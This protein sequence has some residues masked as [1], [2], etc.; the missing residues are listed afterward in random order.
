M[1]D[2]DALKEIKREEGFRLK[3]YQD[4]EGI[5]TI[6]YG[7][8]LQTLSISEDQADKW[9]LEDYQRAVDLAESIPE[10]MDLSR[11]RKRVIAQMCFQLGLQGLR[12]FKKMW[13]AVREEDWQ[14]AYDEMLDS[15]WAKQTPGRAR[16]MATRLL[17]DSWPP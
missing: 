17:N 10:Y 11:N 15:K 3:A 6:G 13:A 1:T 8:N 16:R 14:D 4:S 7:R 2:Y 9:L 12:K 5:W